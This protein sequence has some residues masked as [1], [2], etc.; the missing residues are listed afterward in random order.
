MYIEF[1]Q[2]TKFVKINNGQTQIGN[3]IMYEGIK[4]HRNIS[5][6]LLL[7]YWLDEMKFVV[8]AKNYS[9]YIYIFC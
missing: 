6:L 7:K 2:K 4:F 9:L 5:L 1:K 3:K 8:I